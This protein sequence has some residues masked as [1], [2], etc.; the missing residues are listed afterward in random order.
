MGVRHHRRQALGGARMGGK[1]SP[2]VPLTSLPG[3]KPTHPFSPLLRAGSREDKR[4]G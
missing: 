1:L 2:R 4:G 3:G